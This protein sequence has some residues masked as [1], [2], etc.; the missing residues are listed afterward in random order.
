M[1]KYVASKKTKRFHVNLPLRQQCGEAGDIDVS[2]MEYFDTVDE[3]EST[4]YEPCEL[5]VLKVPK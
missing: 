4:G 3:A 5:C 1:H 2:D